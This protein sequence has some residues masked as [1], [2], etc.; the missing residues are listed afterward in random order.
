MVTEELITY[1]KRQQSNHVPEESI[2]AILLSNGWLKVD[3]DK[4][5]DSLF[6]VQESSV[7]TAS[8]LKSKIAS[9]TPEFKKPNTSIDLGSQIQ[10]TS[11]QPASSLLKD[12]YREQID[13][14]KEQFTTQSIGGSLGTGLPDDLKDRLRKISSGSIFAPQKE[15]VNPV[16]PSLT[17][18]PNPL[19]TH[20]P[21]SSPSFEE[22]LMAQTP[23][24]TQSQ[25]PIKRET[26]EAQPMSSLHMIE[27]KPL[28]APLGN[29]NRL[30]SN[31][32][33]GSPYSP[34]MDKFNNPVA[35]TPQKRGHF[36]TIVFILFFVGL[37]GGGYYLYTQKPD[38][39][40]M[41]I[42]KILSQK[43]S[44]TELVTLDTSIEETPVTENTDTTNQNIPV[45]DS[46]PKVET[47]T[48]P[49]AES[50]LKAIAIKIPSYVG[51]KSTTKG[52]CSNIS[53]GIAKDIIELR[54]SYGSTVA[55]IDDTSG[56]AI[57]VPYQATGE[58]MC[59]DA[60]QEI[61]LIKATPKTA[62]CI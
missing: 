21:Q 20:L 25:F 59:I 30:Y 48:L 15:I 6:K 35:S 16:S 14:P 34:S 36:G 26:I 28:G 18:E 62:R 24:Q 2:R 45:K 17:G 47:P 22:R 56:F 38:L 50:T 3:V 46:T 41:Y 29:E 42:D 39:V 27:D 9:F 23:T 51:I 5:F 61:V 52:V 60:T 1:I 43:I 11:A 4:A 13:T 54:Q 55:C 57:S 37:I 32:K 53:S 7:V 8:D 33:G 40:R 31:F 10:S 44:N 58:F 12:S 19:M 49:T